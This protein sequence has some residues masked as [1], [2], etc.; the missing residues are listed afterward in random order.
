MDI[1]KANRDM[2]ELDPLFAQRVQAWLNDC[3]GAI[4]IV[5]GYRS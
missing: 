3:R 5:E 4:F 1:T 2:N